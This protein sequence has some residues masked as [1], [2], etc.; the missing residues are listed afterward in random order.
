MVRTSPDLESI[1]AVKNGNVYPCFYP[2]AGGRPQDRNLFNVIYMAKVLYPDEFA[3]LDLE[4]EGNEIFEAFL[5]VDGVF[6]EYADWLVWPREYL[7]VQ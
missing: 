2:Y 5:G 6:T 3:D 7:E 4:E 1:R